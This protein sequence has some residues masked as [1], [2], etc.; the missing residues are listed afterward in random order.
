MA[1]YLEVFYAQ[2]AEEHLVFSPHVRV[3][4]F[5]LDENLLFRWFA[6]LRDDADGTPVLK[7]P[8]ESPL[9][10]RVLETDLIFLV[11]LE[12]LVLN[13]FELFSCLGMD[14][15]KTRIHAFVTIS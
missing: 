8:L 7:Q 4:L 12:R 9:D 3:Q 13:L 6:V 11:Y 14:H 1:I 15:L 5:E 2:V 10:G